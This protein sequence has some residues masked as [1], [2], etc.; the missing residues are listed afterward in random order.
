MN[1]N[2][3][4]RGPDA[5]SQH[6]LQETFRGG[7]LIAHTEGKSGGGRGLIGAQR[8]MAF[9][10]K[11]RKKRDLSDLEILEGTACGLKQL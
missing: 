8:L 7:G 4:V 3:P 10:R 5:L 9:A 11:D 1:G 2:G 6:A